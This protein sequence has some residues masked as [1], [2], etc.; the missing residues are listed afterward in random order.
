[1]SVIGLGGAEIGFERAQTISLPDFRGLTP[2]E[3]SPRYT[4]AF[5]FADMIAKINAAY[6]TADPGWRTES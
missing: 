5:P 1:M 6:D 3:V 2:R 4:L